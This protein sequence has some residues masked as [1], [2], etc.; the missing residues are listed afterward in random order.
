MALSLLARWTGVDTD[1]DTVASPTTLGEAGSERREDIQLP[2]AQKSPRKNSEA[3]SSGSRRRKSAAP[4]ILLCLALGW[5]GKAS[6]AQPAS[7]PSE[8]SQAEALV[9]T[10]QWAEGLAA[11][12]PLLAREPRNLRALNLAALACTGEGDI[13]QADRYFERA[14]GIDPKFLP[15]LK[16]LAINEFN[17]KQTEAASQHLLQARAEA[18]D[19]PV[20]NLYLG[21]LAYR[22]GDFAQAAASLA[23]AGPFLARDA[24][25][26][27]QL[28]A[29]DLAIGDAAAAAQML[30]D[31]P[32]G[33]LT[34]EWQFVLGAKLASAGLFDRAIPYL[35]VARSSHPESYDASFDLAWSYVGVKRYPQAIE[36]LRAAIDRGP[37]T[38]ELE[39]AL[40]EAYEGNNQTQQAV[41][42]FRRAIA[43]A[44]DDEEGYLDFASVC[45]DH[46]DFPAALKVL[47]LGLQ[48]HPKSDQLLFER[49]IFY[50][51]QDNFALA[52]KD[53]EQAAK[54]AP[55]K[56]ASYEGLGVLYL[57]T[58]NA[59]QAAE[60]IRKRLRER[61]D[62]ANLLYLLGE[63]LLQAGARCGQPSFV[64]AQ[65]ALERS[66]QL[67]PRLCLPHVELGKIYLEEDR[68]ADAV[69]Q[70]EQARAINPREKATYW[71]LAV[72][73][74]TLGAKEKQ[75]EALH[76]LEELD[77]SERDG[78]RGQQKAGAEAGVSTSAEKATDKAADKSTD[79]GPR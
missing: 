45:I 9:R 48:L 31:L 61:P 64:D 52:Q 4:L 54:L 29:S 47:Q 57:E 55:E 7:A 59:A 50:A 20:V 62:D 67:D 71:Q 11:L 14:L 68:A 10:H 12:Q 17:A 5:R 76:A 6:L 39:D 26:R 53:F 60:T 2:E 70:L 18:P 74:R 69:A 30:G 8:Y 33:S 35:Q 58:G 22:R 36:V 27:A 21:Q 41:D 16:N 32:P 42:A 23:K 75:R 43:I 63:A 46:Q 28:A 51:M 1:A 73:Y 34:A 24:D 77:R 78:S 25:L 44:P 3:A 79:P 66:I 49:G 56:D 40:G 37:D 15:A 13:Q 38:A 72:A 19:D 65:K